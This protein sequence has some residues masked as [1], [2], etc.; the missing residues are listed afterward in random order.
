MKK[1]ID[2]EKILTPE[3]YKVLREKGTEPPF[4]GK[5]DD[6]YKEGIYLC[7]GCGAHLF[8]SED[9][10]KSGTGWPSFR[11]PLKEEN[12]TLEKDLS[13]GM[14][15][16][17]AICSVCEGHLGH[18]F[19]EDTRYCINSLSLSF[20]SNEE[21]EEI[22]EITLNHSKEE[23]ALIRSILEQEGIEYFIQNEG[24]QDLFGA[25]RLGT[26]VNNIVGEIKIS[27]QKKNKRIAEYLI[28]EII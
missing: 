23:I 15:R 14:I 10:F 6:F 16:T 1:T 26:G 27:V 11:K 2:W 12:I 13:F 18:Y 4:S 21:S 25:G 9:K 5:Y 8:S 22:E 17:E 7:K 20:V 19:P 24:L 3:E 28:Y